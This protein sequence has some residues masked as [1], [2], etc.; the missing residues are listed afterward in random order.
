MDKDAIEN[1]AQAPVPPAR[2]SA[3]RAAIEAAL[4]RFDD[5]TKEDASEKVSQTPK[6]ADRLAR[7]THASTN[8]RPLMRALATPHNFAIAASLAALVIAAPY[9]FRELQGSLQLSL[10]HI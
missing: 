7:Q 3:R 2:E 9:A 6:E 4:A 1:L 5:A 8:R 10:I